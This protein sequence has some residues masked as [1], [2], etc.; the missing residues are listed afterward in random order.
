MGVDIVDQALR[1]DKGKQGSNLNIRREDHSPYQAQPWAS[2]SNQGNG[3]RAWDVDELE[4]WMPQGMMKEAHSL[5]L[6]R[7]SID[8]YLAEGLRTL[9]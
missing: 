6:R 1:F 4:R 3:L 2:A 7:H 8:F 9:G 5:S